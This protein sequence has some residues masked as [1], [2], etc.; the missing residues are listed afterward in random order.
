MFLK[1]KS[2]ILKAFPTY[3]SNFSSITF[4]A[5]F[6]NL[7]K[8]KH[9]PKIAKPQQRQMKKRQ[10]VWQK[11]GKSGKNK[12]LLWYWRKLASNLN[13]SNILAINFQ[14]HLLWN[15]QLFYNYTTVSKI[16]LAAAFVQSKRLPKTTFIFVH[17]ALEP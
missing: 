3:G 12:I 10:K 8:P 1:A 15:C 14:L 17:D 4:F 13:K 5:Y 9:K 16:S 7:E 11:F 6:C 2:I